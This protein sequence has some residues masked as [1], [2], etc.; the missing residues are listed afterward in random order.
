MPEPP[1][2]PRHPPHAHQ[3]HPVL[4]WLLDALPPYPGNRVRADA[5]DDGLY[6]DGEVGPR[7]FVKPRRE[8]RQEVAR[9]VSV[10]GRLRHVVG[11]VELV[12]QSGGGWELQFIGRQ[13]APYG[14]IDP[15]WLELLEN[16]YDR[17]GD[18]VDLPVGERN[19]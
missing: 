19:A 13:G 2:S 16:H 1:S 3:S 6:L 14:E 18:P 15:W 9:I 5:L 11:R 4:G 10:V 7:K 17:G 8:H 12:A